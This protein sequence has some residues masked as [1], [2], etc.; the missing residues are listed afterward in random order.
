MDLKAMDRQGLLD[1]IE[2]L[3]K[4][5]AGLEE[6]ME[7]LKTQVE[8][9]GYDPDEFKVPD[10]DAPELNVPQGTADM[11]AEVASIFDD[12]DDVEVDPAPVE[13]GKVRL[14]SVREEETYIPVAESVARTVKVKVKKKS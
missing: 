8:A 3:E 7:D 2:E 10:V 9:F 12:F 4:K 5:T 14:S 11:L 6:Q 13:N 1:Y